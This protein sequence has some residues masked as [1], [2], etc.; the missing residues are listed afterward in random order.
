MSSHNLRQPEPVSIRIK[1][2]NRKTKQKKLQE[3]LHIGSFNIQKTRA[4]HLVA[5]LASNY[6]VFFIQEFPAHKINLEA[7]SDYAVRAGMTFHSSPTGNRIHNQTGIFIKRKL[8]QTRGTS[9]LSLDSAHKRYVTDVRVQLPNGDQLLLI[10]LYLPSADK[11]LQAEILGDISFSLDPLKERFPSLKVLFGGDMNHSMENTPSLER[12]AVVA[13]QD[14]CFNSKT[15]DVC[16]YDRLISLFPTNKAQTCRRID[17]LYAPIGWRVRSICYE[18]VKPPVLVSS[19]HLISICYKLEQEKE[20][21]IGQARFQFP[22]RRLLPPFSAARTRRIDRGMSL[23]DALFSIQCDGMEYIRLMGKIRKSDPEVA[24][25]LVDDSMLEIEEEFRSSA[26]KTFFQTKRREKTVFTIL[27]NGE[28]R[29][30][31]TETSKMLALASEYYRGLYLCPEDPS[32]PDL[33]DFLAPMT[34][35]LTEAQRRTLD[36]PFS[37]KELFVALQSTDKSTAPG[38]DGIQYP[39]IQ[40]YWDD[41]G[42]ILT[43]TANKIMETGKLP[44]CL[45]KV[46]ITLIPKL[47]QEESHDIKD[48]RPILLSN[49]AL[50][51][52]STAATARLQKVSDSL[53][54][55]H[56]RG[57]MKGRRIN[58]NTMEFF[59]MLELIKKHRQDSFSSQFQAILMADFTKA[60]DRISHKYMQAVLKK[61]GFGEPMIRLMMLLMA[62]QEAQ[63]FINNCPGVPFPMRCGTRQGNPLSPMIFNLALEPFLCQLRQLQGI[64]ILYESIPLDR[65]RYHA[66]ADDVNIYLND[67]ADYAV[68]AEIISKYERCSNSKINPQKSHLLGF[69]FEYAECLQCHLPFPQSF[70]EDKDLNYLGLPLQGVDWTKFQSNLPFITFKQGFSRLDLITKAQ[71]TNTFVA[72]T[73]VYKDLVLCMPTRTLKT[74]DRG[75]QKLFRGVGTSTIY[76]RPKK[77]GYGVIQL[78]IQLQGHRAAVLLHTLSDLADWY[79]NLWRIKML[80]HMARIIKG[81]KKTPVDAIGRLCWTDFLLEGSGMFFENL[82]WTFS[83]NE[84]HYLQ[85]WKS[86]VKGNRVF[87]KP[88]SLLSVP[89]GRIVS[90]VSTTVHK[91][92]FPDVF[93][94]SASEE[95]LLTDIPFRSLSKEKQES[96]PVIRPSR[97]LE[98]CPEVNTKK[99]WKKF[100]NEMYHQE[101]VR[102]KDLTAV[103]HFNLG[104]YVP[105]H[106]TKKRQ[107]IQCLLCGQEGNSKAILS[108]IYNSCESSQFWWS[109]I[110]FQSEMNLREMLAPIDTSSSNLLRINRF[111]KVVY[112]VYCRRLREVRH[113]VAITPLLV[114]QLSRELGQTA[115][116]GR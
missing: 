95:K 43:R 103:H 24:R 112:R 48:L 73:M 63:I 39:V 53:I 108:H 10:N 109:K 23:E 44:E 113:S 67:L 102:R 57:F 13:V 70:I 31:A 91:G 36:L 9:E 29:S 72:S 80:H 68:T 7:I 19:H 35:H 3:R 56:Q 20:I 45:K 77:G 15:E 101:W 21:Q 18:I 49:T 85:A 51:L 8:L 84:Q 41:I 55:P 1:H 42:P 98:I 105:I 106:D 111:V 93:A 83:S 104:S 5:H 52:I 110:G 50:K 33:Q 79:T 96:L 38:P 88:E 74:I 27:V 46:L 64:P 82:Q 78:S 97:F 32:E 81:K 54:G 59:T 86:L 94:I 90:Y 4:L 107:L 92:F 60:F 65:M 69:D 99:R 58:Q 89:R 66:F 61:A 115:P 28:K 25:Q 26:T 114:K 2:P 75:I 12:A 6:D 37:D 71:A 100:W 47:G 30:T 87:L 62:D 16:K 17:R 34:A 22:L 14:L 40:K 11:M 76:A 116:L